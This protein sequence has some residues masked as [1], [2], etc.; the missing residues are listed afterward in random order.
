[1]EELFVRKLSDEDIEAYESGEDEYG[2]IVDWAE[3]Q[4]CG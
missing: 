2:D 4:L 3:R 1:M